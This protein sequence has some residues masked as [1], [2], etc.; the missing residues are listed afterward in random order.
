MKK[1]FTF[2]LN[3]LSEQYVDHGRFF[4]YKDDIAFI[5]FSSGN[6]LIYISCLVYRLIVYSH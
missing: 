5:S 2:I 4:E 3:K 1:T 6:I